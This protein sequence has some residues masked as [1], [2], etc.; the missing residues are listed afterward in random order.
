M[1]NISRLR[2]FLNKIALVE[3]SV[4]QV[5]LLC[6]VIAAVEQL[7]SGEGR[8]HW[9]DSYAAAIWFS[10]KYPCNV[11]DAGDSIF[12]A[13]FSTSDRSVSYG[14]ISYNTTYSAGCMCVFLKQ[15]ILQIKLGA[16]GVVK[17]S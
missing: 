1:F 11:Q 15:L 2:F 8:R 10:K 13:A 3:M 9:R 4:I 16:T 5:S 14:I 12:T 17:S 6:T 7:S